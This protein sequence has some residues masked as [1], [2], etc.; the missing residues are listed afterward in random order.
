MMIVRHQK[1]TRRRSKSA[2]LGRSAR[3]KFHDF[4][5]LRVGA[6]FCFLSFSFF[7]FFGSLQA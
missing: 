1:S 4:L 6:L 7:F 2:L 3:F 5:E